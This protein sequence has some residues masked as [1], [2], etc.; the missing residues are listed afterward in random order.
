LKSQEEE[1]D[2]W[3]KLCEQATNEQNPEK[4]VA[5]A[6]EINQLLDLKEKR[7]R[8]NSSPG[9]DSLEKIP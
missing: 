2:L 3:W 6:K 7:L 8:E 4:V 5:L 9:G 1:A